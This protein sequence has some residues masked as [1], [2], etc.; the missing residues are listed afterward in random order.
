VK[1]VAKMRKYNR[2]NSK[3]SKKRPCPVKEG[4]HRSNKRG[5]SGKQHY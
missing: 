2:T 1:E 3:K 4:H 5:P